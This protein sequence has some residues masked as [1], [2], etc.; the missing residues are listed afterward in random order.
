MLL[1][2]K[3][4]INNNELPSKINKLTQDRR[5]VSRQSKEVASPLEVLGVGRG[6]KTADVAANGYR[7]PPSLQIFIKT[8]SRLE[9]R[10]RISLLQSPRQDAQPAF[11]CRIPVTIG[12]KKFRNFT[13]INRKYILLPL[14]ISF[15]YNHFA[16]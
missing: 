7:Q 12:V 9:Y 3:Y 6:L 2:R 15:T 16:H 14:K 5:G 10:L 8:F 1:N 13:A 4:L 11:N